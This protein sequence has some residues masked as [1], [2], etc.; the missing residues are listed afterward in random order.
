MNRA[1]NAVNI[2]IST[3]KTIFRPSVNHCLLVIYSAELRNC[4]LRSVV[5][6]SDSIEIQLIKFH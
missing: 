6:V 3:K 1:V 4:S 5:L 2:L